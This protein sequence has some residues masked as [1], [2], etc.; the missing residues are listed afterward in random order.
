MIYFVFFVLKVY[1]KIALRELT[2]SR[3]EEHVSASWVYTKWD[4][5]IRYD[6]NHINSVYKIILLDMI[7][8]ISALLMY[9]QQL[10]NK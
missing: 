4:N 6:C 3:T 1:D 2:P 10:I 7:V 5:R 9:F 8:I